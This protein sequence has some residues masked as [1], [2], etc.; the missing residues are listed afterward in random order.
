MLILFDHGTPRGLARYL[1]DHTVTAA[2]E[3]GWERLSNGQL[4]QAAEEADFALF[5]TTDQRIQYQQNLADRRI[6]IVVLTGTSKWSQVRLNIARIASA[7][8]GSRPGA[9]IEVFTPFKPRKAF[10][11]RP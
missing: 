8:S 11:P 2:K 5:L 10:I 4:I 1:P 6:A 7:V 9:Y 3:L